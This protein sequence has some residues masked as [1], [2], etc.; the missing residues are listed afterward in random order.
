[1]GIEN[2]LPPVTY[3]KAI[4]VWIFMCTSFVFA[5]LLE[6]SVANYVCRMEGKGEGKHSHFRQQASAPFLKI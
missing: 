6:F 4:D 2:K 3:L 5:A 1:M